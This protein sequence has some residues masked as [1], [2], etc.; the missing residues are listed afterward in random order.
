MKDLEQKYTDLRTRVD[1]AMSQR[2]WK[3]KNGLWTDGDSFFVQNTQGKYQEV[4]F[5]DKWIQ[6]SAPEDWM[7]YGSDFF[8]NDQENKRMISPL[9]FNALPDRHIDYYRKVNEKSWITGYV[10]EK[11]KYYRTHENPFY[12]EKKYHTVVP[13]YRDCPYED[14]DPYKDTYQ[15]KLDQGNE[16]KIK[17]MT[18]DKKLGLYREHEEEEEPI[19]PEYTKPVPHFDTK[20]FPFRY[21]TQL[22]KQFLIYIMG[23]DETTDKVE[24]EGDILT[25]TSHV[26]IREKGDVYVSTKPFLSIE[27]HRW[28]ATSHKKSNIYS[29]LS[30]VEKIFLENSEKFDKIKM[31]HWTNKGVAE[32]MSDESSDGSL[33]MYKNDVRIKTLEIWNKADKNWYRDGKK[34]P[35]YVEDPQGQIRF[36]SPEGNYYEFKE[37]SDL[38]YNVFICENPPIT[39]LER[40]SYK[41]Y[42]NKPHLLN[43]SEGR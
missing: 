9:A 34:C 7:I 24:V 32:M 20:D 23:K 25:V 31:G 1:S 22:G 38:G 27:Y 16:S 8:K 40:I 36:T 5:Y 28:P 14:Y 37:Q 41:P 12:V 21:Y 13:G 30:P 10:M 4:V 39:K 42:N 33:L 19:P 2:T 43:G 15:V 26:T 35:Y 17:V 29:S 6:P 11:G 18:F 3:K